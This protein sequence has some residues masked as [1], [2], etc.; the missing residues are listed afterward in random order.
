MKQR[1]NWTNKITQKHTLWAII[2]AVSYFLINYLQTPPQNVGYADSDELLT[3]AFHRGIAHPPGYPL[4]ISLLNI[5]L[6]LPFHAPSLAFKGHLLSAVASSLTLALIYLTFIRLYDALRVG[7]STKKILV[8]IHFEKWWFAIITSASLA[9]TY[10]FWLYSHITEKYALAGLFVAAYLFVSIEIYIRKKVST[11]LWIALWAILGFGIS[12]LQSLIILIPSSVYLLWIKQKKTI[13]NAS[14]LAVIT[15]IIT[16]L[17][18]YM[19]LLTSK[20]DAQVS[21]RFTPSVQGI[22]EL[23]SRQDFSGLRYAS[24]RQAGAYL[25]GFDINKYA[26]GTL[27]YAKNLI[28]H[29]GWWVLL[30]VLLAFR[31]GQ[32]RLKRGFWFILL[33]S[34]LLSLGF[35]GFIGMP[36]DLGSQAITLR[37][38]I[39]G[40]VALTLLIYLGW[41]EFTKR[42]L[43]AGTILMHKNTISAIV[44]LIPLTLIS[45]HAYKT[46]PLADLSSYDHLA[47]RYQDMMHQFKENS[48]VTCYSDVSC[49]ALLY[50]RY[51]NQ[52]R[53]D[54]DVIPLAY[55]LVNDLVNNN[56]IRGFKET[57]QD[58]P[59]LT[60]D[61]VTWNIGKRPVYAVELSTVYYNLLG[62]DGPYMYYIPHG[63]YGELTFSL[64]QDLPIPARGQIDDWLNTP[65]IFIDP[66]RVFHKSTIAK[67][68]I[69]NGSLY[70]KMDKRAWALQEFNH[71]SNIF[72]QLEDKDKSNF[73][74]LRNQLEHV[75]PDPNFA[76]GKSIPTSKDLLS[77]IAELMERNQL[78]HAFTLTHA[79]MA[80]DPQNID[81]RL[82]LADI[83][84]R[85]G[86]PDFALIEYTN[87]IIL[88]PTNLKALENINRLSPDSS[89]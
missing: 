41:F 8:S 38:Y 66:M 44:I 77:Y 84:E 75:Q 73:T 26:H 12:H 64:P 22:Y 13:Q 30:L 1:L 85:I 67:D 70:V 59:Y 62:I 17:I 42:L 33:A 28:S 15:V 48:I 31:F 24:G 6:N 45:S 3:V 53:T 35:A 16:F 36:E 81:A 61:I 71:A 2:I 34:T 80:R 32:S 86:D 46:Y 21:W 76:P 79:A 68:Y 58:N 27:E 55:P 88:D 39:P 51:V 52:T 63:S 72:F 25:D 5:F 50:E 82:L 37:Q 74:N 57:Y 60:I 9:F 20:Q 49:F 65:T 19:L 14:F 4:Y 47:T 10:Q 78:R 89:L 40:Y 83:Y 87:A 69:L 11:P 54:I 43:T 56:N 18:P 29:S 23:I 7:K